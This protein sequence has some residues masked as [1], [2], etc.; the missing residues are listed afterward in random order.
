MKQLFKND[1]SPFMANISDRNANRIANFL[2]PMQ[3]LLKQLDPLLA[4]HDTSGKHD[5]PP[6]KEDFTVF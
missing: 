5:L 1:I 4:F 2:G 3:P 6:A